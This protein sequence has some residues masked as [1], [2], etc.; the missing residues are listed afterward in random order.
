MNISFNLKNPSAKVSPIRLIVT[1]RGK[2]YR[3]AVGVSVETSQWSKTKQKTN[4]VDINRRLS[5]IRVALESNLNE[6]S[7]QEEI[8]DAIEL[9]LTGQTVGKR[10]KSTTFI[11]FAYEFIK[12]NKSQEAIK[13]CGLKHILSV[14]GDKTTWDKIDM[15][16][17]Y[18]LKNLV[19]VG[20]LKRST[21]NTY[22]VSTLR[23]V[24]KRAQELGLHNNEE[25]KKFKTLKHTPFAIYLNQNDIEKLKNHL[26][27]SRS[28]EEARDLFIVGVYT[29]ARYSDFSR[30]SYNNIIDGHI[31]F[32]QKKTKRSVVIPLAPVV[33]E[34]LDKYHGVLPRKGIG[35]FNYAIKQVCK[36]AGID[37]MIETPDGMKHKY[38]L[39]SAHTARR[40]G[41][42]ILYMNGLPVK[43][44]MMV[45][46]HASESIFYRYVK[47]T[48]E[49]SMEIIDKH[50]FFK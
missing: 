6:F 39:V 10:K 3:S 24:M 25:Y 2:V 23:C 8:A 27:R 18:K 43:Q 7:K 42:T 33:K 13:R 5:E 37:E 40:T 36:C 32:T 44:C 16:L 31:H 41:A 19:T 30:L 26:P 12:E 28:H 45:T 14:Y 1:H 49:E 15:D 4:N 47:T 17:Y 50:E 38:E 20:R 21:F 11:E 35:A 29:A 22:I 46:G 9:A 48:A 34:V